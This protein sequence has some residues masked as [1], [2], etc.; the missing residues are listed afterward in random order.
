MIQFEMNICEEER[1]MKRVLGFLT[2]AVMVICSLPSVSFAAERSL[3][4]ILASESILSMDFDGALPQGVTPKGNIEYVEGVNGNALKFDGNGTYLKLPDNLNSGLTDFTLSMW[5]RFDNL[6]PDVWQR[7]FDIHGEGHRSMFFGMWQYNRSNNVRFCIEDDE[8][9]EHASAFGVFQLGE[10][11]NYTITQKGE[12]RALYV[13]GRKLATSGAYNIAGEMGETKDNYIG[14]TVEDK[15]ADFNGALDEF[16]FVKEALDDKQVLELAVKYMDDEKAVDAYSLLTYLNFNGN[17]AEKMFDYYTFDDGKRSVKWSSSRPDLLTV[18]GVSEGAA[19]DELTEVTLTATV[20]SGSM[21]KKLDYKLVIDSSLNVEYISMENVKKREMRRNE[22]VNYDTAKTYLIKKDGKYLSQK[23]DV[24]CLVDTPDENAKW[25][26][27]KSEAKNTYAIYNIEDGMC[28]NVRDYG[29]EPGCDV[30]LY[31]GGKGINENWYFVKN[32]GGVSI[33]S[34]GSNQFFNVDDKAYIEG[35]DKADVW[36]IEETERGTLTVGRIIDS[37]KADANV[38]LEKMDEGVYYKFKR[39]GAYMSVNDGGNLCVSA[40]SGDKSLWTLTKITEG[41]YTITS[42]A[43]DKNLNIS[44]NSA[45]AGAGVITWDRGTAQNEQWGFIKTD[46]GYMITGAANKNY[47]CGFGNSF[48]MESTAQIW[49]LETEE[50]TSSGEEVSKAVNPLL[51]DYTPEVRE[52]IDT[53]T[54]FIHPGIS[55]NAEDIRRIQRHVRNG[56]EPWSSAF[57][58]LSGIAS[59]KENPRIHAWDGDGDTTKLIVEVR[60]KNMRADATTSANQALMYVIT[61]N[62]AYRKNAINIIRKWSELRDVYATL[63]SDRIDHGAIA[64]KMSFAAELLKY[65]ST[66]NEELRWTEHDNDMFVGMLETI[67]PKHNR[68]W[69]WMN[70]HGICNEG[71]M[72]SAIFRNDLEQY[73]TA[74]VRTTVNPE[75]GGEKALSGGAIVQVFKLMTQDD[76][77]GEPLDEP[78]VTHLEMGRDMGHAYDNNA[79]LGC[80]AMMTVKQNTLVDPVTGEYTTDKNGV[81]VFEFADHRLLKA[82]NLI[83][84]YN[85]GYDVPFPTAD[86]G[87]YYYA[88]INDTNRGNLSNMTGDVYSYYKYIA[89]ADMEDESI[90]Y[91]TQAYEARLPEGPADDHLGMT[92]LLYTADEGQIDEMPMQDTSSNTTWQSEFCTAVNY[93]SAEKVFEG[94]DAYLKV[95]LENGGTRFAQTTVFYAPKEQ[96]KIKL[97][98][99]THG[100]VKVTIQNEHLMYAPFVE[101]IIPDTMG[102]WETVEFDRLPEATINQRVMFF[103]LS[104]DGG[105]MDIDYM[106]FSD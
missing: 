25:R 27:A 23:D 45:N 104:G 19:T 73:K 42:K 96:S 86:V 49:A 79:A 87:G 92:T 46:G 102:E 31:R 44:G 20:K 95:S 90:K 13:N 69:H 76:L 93:G 34:Y 32:G 24:L 28:L 30:L 71:T 47:L 105:E 82:T 41:Y 52:E 12:E 39:S 91:L 18:D 103:T 80:C 89:K 101:A 50:N 3:E 84:K 4:D 66:E 81:N 15:V 1:L 55:I 40:D 43:A 62:E 94:G 7:V 16:V 33:L 67:N 85:L 35:L 48:R 9:E 22:A 56:D 38:V 77:L 14:H 53:E 97:R 61:G 98:V 6:T 26:L 37:E 21:E 106:E 88:D 11:V 75:G 68:F 63:G 17:E 29:T 51:T 74:V 54:G 57:K 65:T 78:T 64:Y 100:E 72:A 8:G 36:T 59:A 10:W 5:V 83:S 58:Q 70:Q 99:R 60:L 2:A